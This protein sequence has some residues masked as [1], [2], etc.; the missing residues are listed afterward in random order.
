MNQNID[1]FYLIYKELKE[2]DKENFKEAFQDIISNGFIVMDLNEKVYTFIR[3]NFELL[4]NFFSLIGFDLVDRAD[5]G[6]YYIKSDSNKFLKNIKKNDTIILLVLRVLY[7]EQMEKVTISK[8]VEIKYDQLQQKLLNINFEY[9]SKERVQ[10]SHIIDSLKLLRSHNIIKFVGSKI[11]DDT[12]I[13]IYP[14]IEVILD[15]N[16]IGNVL[17]KLDEIKGGID[18]DVNED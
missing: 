15:F 4:N 6:V 8:N 11:N 13:T 2:I 5:I 7:E 12:V 3:L 9:V 14:S 16:L 1:I 17:N 18:D 10:I